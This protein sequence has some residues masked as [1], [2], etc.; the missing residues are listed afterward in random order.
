MMLF[1]KKYLNIVFQIV[2]YILLLIGIFLIYSEG[3]EGITSKNKIDKFNLIQGFIYIG[4]GLLIYIFFYIQNKSERLKSESEIEKYKNEINLFNEKI[5]YL[6]TSK[7]SIPSNEKKEF[8]K[9][10]E[11]YSLQKSL[12]SIKIRL[13]F[14]ISNWENKSIINLVTGLTII[15]INFTF[16]V[17]SVLLSIQDTVTF[18]KDFSTIILYYVPKLLM[19]VFLQIFAYFFLRLYKYGLIEIKYFQN[20]LTNIESKLAAIEIAHATNDN[21][22]M[23]D[24]ISDLLKTE[25]NS[26]L[27]NGESTIE[28]KRDKLES[29]NIKYILKEISSLLKNRG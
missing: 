27:K 21:E 5:T 9:T 17:A 11:L 24:I 7:I 13:K 2:S 23:K 4:I 22:S 26:I 29:D 15:L 1:S 14:E 16:L 20:E 19:V 6:K 12:I 18:S 8:E 10:I 28:L 25:R 3:L